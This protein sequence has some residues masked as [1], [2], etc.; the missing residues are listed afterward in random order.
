MKEMTK[1]KEL[2]NSIGDRSTVK[3]S[4]EWLRGRITV[5]SQH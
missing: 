1:K 5:C 4:K 3:K 2:W